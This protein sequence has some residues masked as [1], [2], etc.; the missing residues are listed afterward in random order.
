MCLTTL[1]HTKEIKKKNRYSFKTTA[2]ALNYGCKRL[3]SLICGSQVLSEWIIHWANLVF[4]TSMIWSWLDWL[5]ATLLSEMSMRG[6][7]IRMR[8]F[9]FEDENLSFLLPYAGLNI[10]ILQFTSHCFL[11]CTFTIYVTLPAQWLL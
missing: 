9:K 3:V 10:D 8:K 1:I 11:P 5:T 2:I 6:F 4:F 7:V